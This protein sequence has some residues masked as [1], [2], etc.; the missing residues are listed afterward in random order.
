MAEEAKVLMREEEIRNRAI[1]TRYLELVQADVTTYFAD[2]TQREP[3]PCPACQGR[4]G[5]P[6]FAKTGFQYVRCHG[7]RT[8]FVTPRPTQAALR[9]YYEAL[10][11]QAARR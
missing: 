6:A 4:E 2:A 7:C 10:D 8:L 3:V 1:F 11:R 9:A 5:E